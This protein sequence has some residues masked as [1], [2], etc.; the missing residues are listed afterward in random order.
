MWTD[1]SDGLK[2]CKESRA[3]TYLKSVPPSVW[4]H[5]SPTRER[6]AIAARDRRSMSGWG[7]GVLAAA[8]ATKQRPVKMRFIVWCGENFIQNSNQDSAGNFILSHCFRL[9]G[10][11]G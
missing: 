9:T 4:S 11:T 6:F 5:P 10:R 7:M 2:L 8:A 3:R 1:E